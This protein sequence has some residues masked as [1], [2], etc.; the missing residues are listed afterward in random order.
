MKRETERERR[1]EILQ[2][3]KL[4]PIFMKIDDEKRNTEINVCIAKQIYE[5]HG[6]Q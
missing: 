4:S 6:M 3:E 1:V 5:L 2:F